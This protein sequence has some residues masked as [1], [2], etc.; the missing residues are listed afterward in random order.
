MVA[1]VQNEVDRIK[2]AL[3]NW[4]PKEINAALKEGW[5][6][7]EC[8]A[9]KLKLQCQKID[10]PEMAS[11][12]AGFEVPD[13]ESDDI[14]IKLLFQGAEP[15]HIL[16]KSIIQEYEPEEWEYILKVAS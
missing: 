16:A 4:T 2:K 12:E 6:L 13:L 1:N 3:L 9:E 5:C 14:A 15:H 10:D 11:H 7:S 8:S